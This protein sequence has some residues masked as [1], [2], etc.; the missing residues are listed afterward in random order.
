[1][2]KKLLCILFNRHKPLLLEALYKRP[3]ITITD[4]WYSS[5]LVEVHM[6]QNCYLVY[7]EVSK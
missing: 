1:M 7:W 6:C 3:L 2:F 4:T 5:D